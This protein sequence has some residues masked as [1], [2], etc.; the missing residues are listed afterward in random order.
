M[1]TR[2][3]CCQWITGIG[4]LDLSMRGGI[5]GI[6]NLT[7]DSFHDGGRY[8]DTEAAV[9]H[10]LSMVAAGASL[11]D[12][13]GESTRPGAE[14]VA[15]REE[16]DRVLPVL[17]RLRTATGVPLSIDTMKAEVARAALDAGASIVNDVSGLRADPEMAGVVAGSDAGLVLMHMQGNPQMMQRAPHYENV[18]EEVATFLEERLA[19][20]ESLGMD[21][22]R[23]VLD[24]GIGF[25]KTR[26][27]NLVLL[28]NMD[29]FTQMGRP[30]LVGVS[31]KSFLGGNGPGDRLWPTVALTALL[32]RRGAR[33]FRVHDV[34][35]NHEALRMTEA[36]LD[37]A[38]EAA[39]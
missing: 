1:M 2:N 27:H 32:R 10:G 38:W 4:M 15:A 36:L 13:G 3:T 7:P 31:R 12:L 17:R 24:P 34:R 9:A 18:G 39:A 29:R 5:M 21:R 11:L 28:R 6:L 30:I 37:P 33:L 23:V 8:A 14:P 19:A 25:G 26:A 22:R 16:I 35:E 20:C